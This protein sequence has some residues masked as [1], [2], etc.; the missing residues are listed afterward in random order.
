M[1]G[2]RCNYGAQQA[3]GTPRVN[4]AETASFKYQG[5][6]LV[7]SAEYTGTGRYTSVVNI[8]G[9]KGDILPSNQPHPSV[10]RVYPIRPSKLAENPI[11][12]G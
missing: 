1:S 9:N 10:Y 4:N 5:F 8:A 6:R 3:K 7:Q 11:F 12:H 2:L